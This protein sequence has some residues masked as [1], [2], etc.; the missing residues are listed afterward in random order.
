MNRTLSALALVLSLAGCD[1]LVLP[2]YSEL[3]NPY[4]PFVAAD[5]PGSGSLE[6]AFGVPPQSAASS[7]LAELKTPEL[8][9]DEPVRWLSVK[10]MAPE[11]WF[12]Q[13]RGGWTARL[14]VTK[15]DNLVELGPA[16]ALQ[17]WPL[18]EGWQSLGFVL[19]SP[20]QVRQVALRL[21]RAG[22]HLSQSVKVLVDDLRVET[23][24]RR[25]LFTLPSGARQIR[26]WSW[27]NS[28]LSTGTLNWISRNS[29]QDAVPPSHTLFS[30][31][32]RDQTVF[33]DLR[34]PLPA[35]QDYDFVQL[36]WTVNGQLR[37]MLLPGFEPFAWLE[38]LPNGQTVTI[39][40]QAFDWSGNGGAINEISVT[41][42][43]MAPQTG[44]KVHTREYTHLFWW[45]S[46]PLEV[47]APP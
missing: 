24:S 46:I 16:V 27:S 19:P 13:G 8:Q 43:Q 10:L 31:I 44:V 1:A 21:E 5:A 7:H 25:V 37:G 42:T 11:S 32:G 20:A 39:R 28:G 29:E 36:S 3:D 22:P 41:P 30:P 40:H 26:D 33:V 2:F 47:R 34:R 12:T 23:A 14:S 4:D 6:W 9:L 18:N 38:G 35:Q 45:D 17:D 15:A